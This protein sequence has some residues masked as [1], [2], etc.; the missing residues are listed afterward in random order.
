MDNGSLNYNS[1]KY[2]SE[3]RAVVYKN[4][5]YVTWHEDDGSKDQIRVKKYDGS[6]WVGVDNGSLNYNSSKHAGRSNAVVYKNELYVTWQ[7]GDEKNYQIRAKKYDGSKWIGVDNGSLNYNSSKNAQRS[8]AVVYKNELYV[9]WYE[10]NG[11][12]YQIV[13]KKYDG[14]KWVGVDNGSLNYDSSKTASDPHAVVYKNELY[15]TWDEEDGRNYQI[16]V[17]KYDGSKWVGLDNGSLNYDSSKFAS[18]SHAVV[19]KNELYVTWFEH[20]GNTFQVRVKKYD[21]SKWVGVDNG[22]LNYDSSKFASDS[23]AVEY[24]N[25]LYIIWTEYNENNKPQIRVKK[26][27]NKTEPEKPINKGNKALLRITMEEG[28]EKEYDMTIKDV[29]D[30]IDWYDKESG[31][32]YIIEKDY[33]IGPFES[34]K[35]YIIKNKIVNFEVMEYNE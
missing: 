30:F 9:T 26:L 25:E 35:D 6:N 27:V 1:Y 22:S 3:P 5:L 33:N 7:E 8:E 2:G 11:D 15:V 29:N 23:H 19:Y 21:G 16:R 12:E 13:S 18:D 34:R 4:D 28:T 24:R 20:N 14:S 31:S 32:Y 10:D 17:K